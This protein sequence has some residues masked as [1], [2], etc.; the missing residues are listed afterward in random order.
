MASCAEVKRHGECGNHFYLLEAGELSVIMDGSE[1]L[2]YKGDYC[3][4]ELALIRE[5]MWAAT[6]EARPDTKFLGVDR[7]GKA[8]LGSSPIGC[9]KE[10]T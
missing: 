3:V 6:A 1:V 7:K 4:G 10:L 2:T 8:Q 9:M 5:E